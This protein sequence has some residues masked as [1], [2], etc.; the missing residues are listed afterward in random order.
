[1]ASIPF[2]F[3]MLLSLSI[4][5]LATSSATDSLREACEKTP[6]P[7]VCVESL[8]VYSESETADIHELKILSVRATT[9]W[10]NDTS[11]LIRLNMDKLN[12]TTP[13]PLQE[14]LVDCSQGMTDA[15]SVLQNLSNAINAKK[16]SDIDAYVTQTYMD[17]ATCS[18]S[19]KG[20][21]MVIKLIVEMTNNIAKLGKITLAF[22]KLDEEDKH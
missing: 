10:A 1:M 12:N 17:T 7:E 9:H 16:L 11:N 4:S 2:N 5:T 20:D 8:S 13:I 14:C 18:N 21:D 3:I 15:I 19:C 6:E 22:A